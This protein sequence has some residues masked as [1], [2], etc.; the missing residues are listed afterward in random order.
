M[1]LYNQIVKYFDMTPD[2]QI[3]WAI[4]NGIV[5]KHPKKGEKLGLNV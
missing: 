3:T 5:N 4:C 2:S 1:S